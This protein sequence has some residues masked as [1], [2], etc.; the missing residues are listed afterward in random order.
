ML[1]SLKNKIK[2]YIELSKFKRK[3]NNINLSKNIII[4]KSKY[5][6]IGENCN[7]GENSYIKC[8]DQYNNT[9][10]LIDKLP[11]LVIGKNF[12]ATRFFSVQVANKIEIGNDC[13][14]GP[15]VFIC[16]Y[17][18]G[19]NPESS[20]YQKN[21][22]EVSD[23][24]IIGNNVWIGANVTILSGKDK[25]IKIGDGVIIGA[26]SVVTK[27]IPAYSIVAGNPMKI[28]KQYSFENHCWIKK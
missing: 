3:N 23:G 9:K 17:N 16:D 13:M 22:L 2:N 26:G 10:I 14:V 24:I 5:M 1:Q 28:I 12:S 15:N 18:H 8:Y 4:Q 11:K 25:S 7:I 6:I 21:K 27:S 19:M 20:T